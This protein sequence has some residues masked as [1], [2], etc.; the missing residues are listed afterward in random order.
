M[1]WILIGIL[2][3]IVGY[4]IGSIILNSRKGKKEVIPVPIIMSYIKCKKCGWEFK[5]PFIRGDYVMKELIEQNSEGWIEKCKRCDG[6][7]I[8]EGIFY[9][10]LK[11]KKQIEF[12]KEMEQWQ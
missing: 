12:E 1:N 7:L 4:V 9:E 6:I 8:V 2:L 10:K 5:R 11:T 3:L